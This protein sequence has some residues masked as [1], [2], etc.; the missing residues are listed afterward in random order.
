MSGRKRPETVGTRV[1]TQEKALIQDAAA[2]DGI[3]VSDFIHQ[4][5]LAAARERLSPG[6][7]PS[8]IPSEVDEE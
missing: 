1:N 7:G 4:V 6:L 5:V 8:D 3:K 2:G